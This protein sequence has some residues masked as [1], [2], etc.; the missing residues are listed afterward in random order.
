[1]RTILSLIAAT[2][3]SALYADLPTVNEADF[4]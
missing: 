2:A 3:V 1:M 4:T